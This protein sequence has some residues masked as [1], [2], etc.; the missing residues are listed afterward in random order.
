MSDEIKVSELATAQKANGDDVAMIL[1]KGVNKKVDINE[2]LKVHSKSTLSITSEMLNNKTITL[3][4]SYQ[5]GSG[6]LDV[7]LN[8]EL[9]KCCSTFDDVDTGHYSE[10]R[11]IWINK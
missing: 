6:V 9:L 8:G 7:Y 3:P 4:I 1:Q 10:V 5:V 2:L 11:N